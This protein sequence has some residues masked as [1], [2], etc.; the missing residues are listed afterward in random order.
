MKSVI[1]ENIKILY[2][3]AGKSSVDLFADACRKSVPV[4]Y[5]TWG[6]KTPAQ[7]KIYIMDWQRFLL[8]ALSW[9]KKLSCVV[10]FPLVPLMYIMMSKRWSRV[11]GFTAPNSPTC[12]VKSPAAVELSGRKLG[13]KIYIQDLNSDSL[14]QAAI[15][16]ELTHAFS[17]HLNL[18]VWLSEGIAM[19]AVDKFTGMTTVK[20]ETIRDI[21]AYQYKNRST[22]YSNLMSG[23]KKS[24]V[25]TYARA[26]WLTRYLEH[27]YPGFIRGLLVKRQSKRKIEQQLSLKTGIPVKDFW[28]EID[29]K[30]VAQ[31]T[32]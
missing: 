6:L 15:C 4:I 7:C 9:P 26:Y 29:K 16:H 21:E 2:N 25:Y 18:P 5:E 30:I 19:Y 14:V 27:N 13:S 8:H 20:A 3:D 31:F 24:I 22:N 12:V 10:L 23:D 17:I 28:N 11:T 32:T 1:A